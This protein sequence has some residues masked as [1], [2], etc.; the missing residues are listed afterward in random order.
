MELALT[1]N[2]SRPLGGLWPAYGVLFALIG[3]HLAF[4][5]SLV[6]ASSLF[7][8]EF[9]A[10]MSVIGLGPAFAFAIS[11]AVAL[12]LRGVDKPAR[13]YFM[14]L[15]RNRF[16]LIR[17]MCLFW[18]MFPVAFAFVAIKVAIPQILPFYLD[19]ALV[20]IDRL[21]FFGFD[22]WQVTHTFIG[23]LGTRFL[24]WAYAAWG[25]PAFLL[26][27]WACFDRNPRFQFASVF[28]LYLCWV[29]LGNIAAI[30]M[31]SVGPIFY[32]NFFGSD[33]FAPLM[34][35]LPDDLN[36]HTAK[37]FLLDAYGQGDFGSG[38][39]AAPSMH[40]AITSLLFLMIRDKFG[41]RYLT[42]I[43]GAYVAMIFVGSIHLAWHYAI[44]GII[45]LIAVPVFWKLAH[46]LVSSGNRR[47]L[48]VA[49]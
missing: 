4:A 13:A 20:Q 18:I 9:L 47:S 19:P 21:L 39:S 15:K 3:C 28:T 44:D 17:S 48:P 41:N 10:V 1:H 26:V 49:D 33:I 45:S 32:E 25:I 29:G 5:A 37:A 12:P 38:I 31:S 2:A 42:L 34:A 23:E 6:P 14:V 22:P 24:D 40:V 27:V 11:L 46:R 16:W 8:L 7:P 35:S 30:L 43:A 36:V